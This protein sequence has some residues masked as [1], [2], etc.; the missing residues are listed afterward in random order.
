MRGQR[1][2]SQQFGTFGQIK[3]VPMPMQNRTVTIKKTQG[4][5]PARLG[6]LYAAPADFLALAGIYAGFEHG[7]NE[8]RPQTDAEQRLL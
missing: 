8:L 2:G 5:L 1:G 7:G 6:E 3:R 4:R